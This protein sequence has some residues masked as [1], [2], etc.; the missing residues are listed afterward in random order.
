[1]CLM[2]P[3]FSISDSRRKRKE[4]IRKVHQRG[5]AVVDLRYTKDSGLKYTGRMFVSKMENYLFTV[6]VQ[7]HP[8]YQSH[9]GGFEYNS[10]LTGAP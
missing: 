3:A 6:V 4:Y 7:N 5:H 1:M 10:E 8:G 2:A 9:R